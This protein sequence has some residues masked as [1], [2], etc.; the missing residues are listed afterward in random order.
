M[1]DQLFLRIDSL[2]RSQG[3]QMRELLDY[4]GL[5]RSTYDNWKNG[6]SKSYTKYIDKI[7]EFLN[8]TPNFLITGSELNNY[9]VGIDDPQELELIST[10]RKMSTESKG[11]LLS[12]LNTFV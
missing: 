2:R 3:R 6:K 11:Y 7:S 1:D 12:L 4:C 9:I 8:V 5:H 10:F